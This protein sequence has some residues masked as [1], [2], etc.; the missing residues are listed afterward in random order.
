[1]LGDGNRLLG[2]PEIVSAVQGGVKVTVILVT[3]DGYQS[4]RNLQEAK[5][6]VLFGTELRQRDESGRLGGDVLA[7]ARDSTRPV[8]I[9][10]PA[11]PYRMQP[12][13]DAGQ[14]VGIAEISQRQYMRDIA[15]VHLKERESQQFYY[16]GATSPHA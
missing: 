13:G 7:V 10:C 3:N 14:G 6:G 1:M 12:G 15:E 11:E 5:T 2:N 8:V 9:V 16:S 4:I